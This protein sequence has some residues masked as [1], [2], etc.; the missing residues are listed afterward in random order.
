MD[1]ICAKQGLERPEPR[2]QRKSAA[3]TMESCFWVGFYSSK[4]L[5][6]QSKGETLL[7]AEDMAAR[8]ALTR[9]F[10]S[11]PVQK[12]IQFGSKVE[13]INFEIHKKSRN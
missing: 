11:D 2:L 3:N 13:S 6:G 1:A 9:F 8:N 10:E 5:I 4:K 12:V 7:I